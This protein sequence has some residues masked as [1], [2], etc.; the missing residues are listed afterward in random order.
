[1]IRNRAAEEAGRKKQLFLFTLRLLLIMAV[2]AIFVLLLLPTSVDGV[3]WDW[4]NSIGFVLWCVLVLLFY[5]DAR[6]RSFPSFNGRFFLNLHRD[7][8]FAAV[9]I[10]SLHIIHQ[11]LS[12]PVLW[13][14]F[15]LAAPPD[16]LAAWLATLLVVLLVSSSVSP[17]R[18]RLW[19][20]YAQFRFWHR[21]ISLLVVVLSAWHILALRAYLSTIIALLLFCASL[22]Y[23]AYLF[24]FER[25]KRWRHD[26]R[27]RSRKLDAALLLTL[28][29]LGSALLLAT[30]LLWRSQDG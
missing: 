2:P 10:L 19:R 4:A 24:F 9:A 13:T 25:R 7:L 20:D 6:S 26:L 29:C 17:L 11:L 5:Y 16:M 14:H 22:C 21:Y 3:A 8:G 18:R 30:I 1:M 23:L 28:S 12:E 27:L 15:S